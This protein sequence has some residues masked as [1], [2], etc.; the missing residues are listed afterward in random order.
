MAVLFFVL[1]AAFWLLVASRTVASLLAGRRAVARSPLP[2]RRRLGRLASRAPPASC[3]L[4]TRQEQVPRPAQPAPAVGV[5]AARRE[6]HKAPY[7]AVEASAARVGLG[8]RRR[9]R[10]G[11]VAR[12]PQPLARSPRARARA[13]LPAPR[14][15]RRRSWRTSP[16]RRRDKD[17]RAGPLRPERRA[18]DRGR[19]PN[20]ED[21][22]RHRG[23][24][25]PATPVVQLAAIILIVRQER[26]KAARIAP[27]PTKHRPCTKARRRRREGAP[28]GRSRGCLPPR[29]TGSS[30]VRRHR[31][32]CA[33]PRRGSLW[34]GRQGGGRTA[35]V[36]P[37]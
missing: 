29:A 31:L 22:D 16:A 19:R 6:G 9:A 20:R 3:L 1:L 14:S 37:R 7:P 12:R 11:V 26:S 8:P 24:H 28:Q 23:G 32:A 2:P 13:T 34:R 36:R 5:A 25:G 21:A 33:A 35:A 15:R 18:G 27:R 30:C 4:Q 10:G 17:G